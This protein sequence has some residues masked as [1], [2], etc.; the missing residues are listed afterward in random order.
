MNHSKKLKLIAALSMI[1]IVFLLC[2]FFFTEE[3]VEILRKI[4]THEL[5]NDQIQEH[6]RTLGIRGQITISLLSMMQ[7]IVAF[8]PAEPVQVLAGLAFGMGIGIVTCAVGVILGNTAIFV[9][10]KIYGD[11]LREYFDRKLAIDLS[12]VGNSRIMTLAIFILYFLPAIP[13]GMICFVAASSG[14]KYHRYIVVTVLGSIPSI[15][16]GVGLGHLALA[17]SWILSVAVF[18]GL[19]LILGILMLKKDYF[20]EKIN[21]Y[22]AAR[23]EPYSSKT[24]V[25]KDYGEWK[26]SIGYFVFRLL[27]FTKVK[28]RMTRSVQK[29][30]HP[31]IVLCNHGAFIDFA[32][33]GTVLKKERPHFIVAR[34]YF[35]HKWL[36][37]LLRTVG[38]FP[39]SMFAMD[40]ESAMNC[41]RVIKS[42][43]VLAMMPEARLSTAG[44]FEDIQDSTFAFLKKMGVHVY[45]IKLSG[46]YLAKPKWA[47]GIR[48]GALVETDLS[49]LFTPE[50]LAELSLEEIKARTENALYYDEF[51]WLEKHPKLHYRSRRMAEGLE[52]ILTR[53]PKCG[54]HYSIVTKGRRVSCEKCDLSTEVNDRYGFTGDVP[55]KNFSEWYDWQTG[56]IKEEIDGNED[57]AL[58]A[59]VELRH[60]SK[61]G[62]TLLTLAGCGECILTREGL[63]Y[64]GTEYDAEIEKHFPIDSIYRLLF[65]A[66]EDFEVYVGKEIYYFTPSERRSCVDFY[67]ASMILYDNKQ[68]TK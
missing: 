54:A 27:T 6:L 8:M 50:E 33:T 10:Y 63:T 28:M 64:K 14:M 11:R 60:A 36:G 52:N 39:K 23:S 38:T 12:K 15:C 51:E 19:V 48:R 5:T 35:C 61:D 17:T 40:T 22:I 13:Y 49:L 24:T 41:V 57:F 45:T 47:K 58:S 67:I 3:N 66:G 68:T 9:L 56:K 53:C 34:L 32:Y 30:E 26:L 43:G 4:F 37:R 42:G 20:L 21:A 7:I 55:F 29:I 65:G 31:S 46:D 44:K 16:I 25:R 2:L 59:P 1:P 62:K 18:A